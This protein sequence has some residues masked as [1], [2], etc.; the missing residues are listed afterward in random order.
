MSTSQISCVIIDDEENSIKVLSRFLQEYCPDVKILGTGNNVDTG[1][2]A[3]L[4][5]NPQ[6]VFLDIEMP[7]G[8][9]FDLL[10]KIG[11]H[12]FHVVFI[13]AYDHYAIQAIKGQA[14]DYILKPVD[15]DDLVSAVEKVKKKIK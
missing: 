12:K 13:T 10:E 7:L 1:I 4:E 15:I 11:T 14:V 2:E 6:L 9:G 8:S 5:H 3:I